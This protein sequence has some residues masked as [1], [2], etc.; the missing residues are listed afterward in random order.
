MSIR[1]ILK[2]D[3]LKNRRVGRRTLR[4]V[5]HYKK[6]VKTNVKRFYCSLETAAA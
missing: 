1:I 5:F 2:G 4:P 6:G 3:M